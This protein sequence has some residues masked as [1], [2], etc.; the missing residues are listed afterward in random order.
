M[1]NSFELPQC[2]LHFW[3]DATDL[4]FAPL[5][6]GGG[7]PEL[8]DGATLTL[9]E[10]YADPLNNYFTPGELA[11]IMSKA[12]PIIP[13]VEF[14]AMPWSK[15]QS[16]SRERLAESVS[17]AITPLIP[18][19]YN[20]V[21]RATAGMGGGY[22]AACSSR[23]GSTTEVVFYAQELAE[24]FRGELPEIGGTGSAFVGQ[25]AR[26]VS[27]GI[28]E[29]EDRDQTPP[30]SLLQVGSLLAREHPEAWKRGV[31]GHSG[32]GGNSTRDRNRIAND[33]LMHAIRS[34]DCVVRIVLGDSP[35]QSRVADVEPFTSGD[36]ARGIMLRSRLYRMMDVK[37]ELRVLAKSGREIAQAACVDEA[38]EEVFQSLHDIFDRYLDAVDR[39]M[40]PASKV[41]RIAD[42]FAPEST[43]S[44]SR[45]P[46]STK[47]VRL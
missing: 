40:E 39:K 17:S 15:W 20:E 36:R 12:Q 45:V 16:Q 3:Y 29:A 28:A 30:Q 26:L 41:W 2:G 13:D 38:N 19:I 8:D 25:I 46:A 1:S 11:D 23:V 9:A 43:A 21:Q 14:Q 31:A 34:D 6:K 35:E 32:G 42:A 4:K 5:R 47:G 24:K 33:F 44:Q 22:F 27:D 37:E 18:D 7:A 10:L